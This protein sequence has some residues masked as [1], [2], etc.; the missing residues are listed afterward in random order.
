MGLGGGTDDLEFSND[1]GVSWTYAP[2]DSGDG[3]DPSTTHIRVRP[4][5]A[6]NGNNGTPPSI[7]MTYEVVLF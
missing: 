5:G 6:F 4:D 2:L 7:N 3:T 1:D